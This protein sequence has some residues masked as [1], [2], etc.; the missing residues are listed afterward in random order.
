MASAL[1]NFITQFSFDG[2]PELLLN[3]AVKIYYTEVSVHDGQMPGD[4]V[5]DRTDFLLCF[6]EVMLSFLA[7]C[8]VPDEA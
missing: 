5:I 6:L 8:D 3:Y 7:L 1:I 2:R 4:R